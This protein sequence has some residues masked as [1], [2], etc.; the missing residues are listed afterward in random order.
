MNQAA[1]SHTYLHW[2][3][4]SYPFTLLGKSLT[5]GTPLRGSWELVK[6]P[7]HPVGWDLTEDWLFRWEWGGFTKSGWNCQVNWFISPWS[8]SQV[9][10][11]QEYPEYHRVVH[12]LIWSQV[13]LYSGAAQPPAG[14]SKGQNSWYLTGA[15]RKWKYCQMRNQETLREMENS[16]FIL[17][18]QS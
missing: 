14:G 10:T 2:S 3:Y 17:C 18:Q 1:H 9:K 16:D 6:L 15:S 8:P 11:N 7:F 13:P 12:H 5:C 4:Y